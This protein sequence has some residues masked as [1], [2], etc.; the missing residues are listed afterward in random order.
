MSAHIAADPVEITRGAPWRISGSIAPA[1]VPVLYKLGLAAVAFVMVLLPIIYVAITAATGYAVYRHAVAPFFDIPS[2]T[3]GLLLYVAPIVVGVLLVFFMIK[4]LFA[5]RQKFTEPHAITA[6][7]EPELF[8]FIDAICDLVHAPRPRCVQIDL[9]VNASASFR[10]GWWSLF[11][12]DLALTVGLPLVAGLSVREFGGVLAHE[13]GHF[14]QGAGMRLTFVVR[15]INA[16]FSRV[17]YERDAWDDRLR[18]A[19]GRADFRIALILQL[20]RGMI[21]LTRRVLWG[22]MMIGHGISCFML[23]QMEFDAD[24]F[25]TEVAGSDAFRSTTKRLQLLNIAW[26]RTL[27]CQ[28]EAFLTRRLV[29]NLPGL[30]AVETSRLP[31]RLTESVERSIATSATGWFDTH[32]GDMERI[33]ASESLAAPGVL[34]GDAPAASLFR[35]FTATARSR[36][37]AYY[38]EE[39][40]IP[41]QDVQLHSTEEMAKEAEASAEEDECLAAWFGPLL[42]IR[43]FVVVTLEELN[44]TCARDAAA[45]AL[46]RARAQQLLRDAEPIVEALLKADGEELAARNALALLEAGFVLK[47]KEFGLKRSSADA[48][49]EAVA[50]AEARIE[51]ERAK[52]VPA[53]EETHRRL[54]Q[55]VAL[56]CSDSDTANE[57]RRLV[58]LLA[59]FTNI[60]DDLVKLRNSAGALELLL[61]NAEN[62]SNANLWNVTAR[63]LTDSAEAATAAII[64]QFG[65][66]DYP[67]SHAH[68]TVRISEFL[69][70]GER[71]AERIP[72][73]SLRGRA[74]LERALTLHYRLLRRLVVLANRAESPAANTLESQP[75]L[76][77][78]ERQ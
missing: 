4:P 66:A 11:R 2:G 31:S 35:D 53:L 9:Q 7:E 14:A 50:T 44:A 34:T 33:R 3:V 39:C 61:G 45:E 24:R 56:A 69:D 38:T 59:R 55:G 78:A 47:A 30:L 13:F 36:T 12:R 62:A 64:E 48:A 72:R 65:D 76:T 37:A 17:V 21:W 19:A 75:T 6:D 20:A 57:I 25:E 26:Q 41:L 8:R 70:A 46:P 16:W 32:P 10:R 1:P 54:L 5:P 27:S 22:L 67:F 43:T 15:S 42:T 52:L 73:A 29:D 23:R 71:H 28:Q 51:Q 58:G 60:A 18:S 63:Q 68:G 74:V 40:E 77:A 49:E